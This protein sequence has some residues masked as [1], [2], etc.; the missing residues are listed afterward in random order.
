[1][2]PA[3]DSTEMDLDPGMAPP[4]SEVKVSVTP[5]AAS[6]FVDP[7]VARILD[8]SGVQVAQTQLRTTT[9]GIRGSL[10][11]P[12]EAKDGGYQVVISSGNRSLISST[13]FVLSEVAF[14]RLRQAGKAERAKREAYRFAAR[15]NLGQA[16]EHLKTATALYRDAG[17][18]H[19]EAETL[20]ESAHILAEFGSKDE[21]LA[22]LREAM[23]K[24][25]RAGLANREI[26]AYGKAQ[27][28]FKKASDLAIELG[29]NR[30]SAINR[31]NLGEVL[32][33]L[34]LHQEAR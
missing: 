16:L 17:W 9:K 13:L 14:S 8:K 33:L 26:A 12:R 19:F 32:L 10:K 2:T 21:Y 22:T 25:H 30:L 3:D 4:G 11:V 27:L 20:L 6:T 15:D 5:Q 7:I 31:N 1:M 23:L 18:A 24:F 34:N 28:Y 29:D